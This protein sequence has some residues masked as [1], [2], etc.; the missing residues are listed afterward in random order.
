MHL[1]KESHFLDIQFQESK[2]TVHGHNVQFAFILENIV[3][4][5]TIIM[6]ETSDRQ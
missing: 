2:Y 5:T 3:F 6:R 4:V 1:R